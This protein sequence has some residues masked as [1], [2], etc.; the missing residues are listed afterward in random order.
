MC[1]PWFSTRAPRQSSGEDKVFPTDGVEYPHIQKLDIHSRERSWTAT[2]CHTHAHTHRE[3][4]IINPNVRAKTTK[5]LKESIC[6]N[7]HYYISDN[8]SLGM[9][10]KTQVTKMIKK[11]LKRT[12]VK[13][14]NAVCYE[15]KKW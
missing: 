12:W 5:L 7:L 10:Q 2:S 14:K 11:I 15:V 3:E 6:V 4:W 8:S 1:G 13:F 9:T